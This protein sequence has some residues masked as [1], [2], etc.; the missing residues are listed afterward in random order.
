MFLTGQTLRVIQEPPPVGSPESA[1]ARQYLK[2]WEKAQAIS[3]DKVL[4]ADVITYDSYK[5]LVYAYGEEGHSVLSRS[6]TRQANRSRP[7]PPRPCS[8]TPRPAGST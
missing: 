5:D 4:S 8:S 6:N 7:A 3:H 1:P 2:T